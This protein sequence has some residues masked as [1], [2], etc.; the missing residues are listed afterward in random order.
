MLS[1]ASDNKCG[2]LLV[3]VSK[4]YTLLFGRAQLTKKSMWV[5]FDSS[6]VLVISFGIFI[7]HNHNAYGYE[8]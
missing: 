1:D 5:E 3:W 8:S 2:L 7:E 6:I 4:I